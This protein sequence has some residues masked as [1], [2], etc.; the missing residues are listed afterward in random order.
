MHLKMEERVWCASDIEML[1]SIYLATVVVVILIYFCAQIMLILPLLNGNCSVY[2]CI[3]LLLSY[4]HVLVSPIDAS[5]EINNFSRNW[6]D[7]LIL[8]LSFFGER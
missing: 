6:Q 1:Y 8:L 3:H 4:I 7:F 2:A 5:I